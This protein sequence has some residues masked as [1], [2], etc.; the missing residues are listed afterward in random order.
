MTPE[1]AKFILNNPKIGGDYRFA[2][3]R[4]CDSAT[5]IIHADGITEDEDK[6]IRD[7]WMTLPG[8]TCYADVVARIARGEFVNFAPP[9][10]RCAW[11]NELHPPRDHSLTREGVCVGCV[12]RHTSSRGDWPSFALQLANPM[13]R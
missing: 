1:R 4:K 10:F 7:A 3:R 8:H 13:K 2:F 11:C 9:I 5:A 12:E 6:F